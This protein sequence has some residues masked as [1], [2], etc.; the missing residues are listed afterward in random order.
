MAI[1]QQENPEVKASDTGEPAVS[2]DNLAE[3]I[4]R[5]VQ[6]REM[7][8]LM[9]SI[10]PEVVRVWAGGSIFK[11]TMV[12]PIAS[13]I[14]K[15]MKKESALASATAFSELFND[16]DFMANVGGE[17]PVLLGGFMDMLESVGK[18][19]ETL[20]A[21]DRA[22]YVAD[23]VASGNIGKAGELLTIFGRVIN[24]VYI[25]N[26]RLL[27]DSLMP[28]LESAIQQTDLGELRET[29]E[30]ATGDIMAL[31]SG[32]WAVLRRYPAKVVTLLSVMPN[33]T[34]IVVYAAKETIGNISSLFQSPD[35]ITDF[36]LSVLRRIDGK[37]VGETVNVSCELIRQLYVGSAL[38]GEPGSPIF[39]RD[40]SAFLA[41]VVEAVD[42]ESLNK[43][44]RGIAEG[45]ETIHK[46][47]VETLRNN[48][49]KFVDYLQTTNEI[50]N[51]RIKTMSDRVALLEDIADQGV[52][53]ALSESVMGVNTHDMAEIIN[54]FSRTLNRVRDDN[55]GFDISTI[56]EF[57]NGVDV[58]ELQDAVKWLTDELGEV[59]RPIGRIFA[60]PLVRMICGWATPEKDGFDQEVQT[61]VKALKNLLQSQEEVDA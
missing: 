54:G 42:S 39:R 7:R 49:E 25:D 2:P 31:I 26:P 19:L 10:A 15:G 29:L 57:V 59:F 52:S 27:T 14:E 47:F 61:A 5:V 50:R 46:S 11:R 36:L 41:E 13:S 43:A 9:G 51:I 35:M 37:T 53:E 45:R 34:N 16:P 6:T 22:A 21:D 24:T 3:L 38:I 1:S 55:P 32:V 20:P 48:P 33:I 18:H 56:A 30:H 40:I 58:D 17:L 12:R 44:R 28:A 4:G 8:E 60:P 23:L